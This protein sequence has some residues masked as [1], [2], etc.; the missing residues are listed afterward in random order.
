MDEKNAKLE[1]PLIML[2]QEMKTNV[3]DMVKNYTELMPAVFIADFLNNL[4]KQYYIMADQQLQIVE[5][6][7]NKSKSEE[8]KDEQQ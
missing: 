1:Q 8:N 4:S 7:Y 2:Y 3:A 5:E 6:D